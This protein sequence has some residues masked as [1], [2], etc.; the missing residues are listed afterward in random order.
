MAERNLDVTYTI[1]WSLALSNVI[2]TGLCIVLAP[3]ISQLTAIRYPLIAPFMMLAISFAAFQATRSLN[4]L[5]A[6]LG[7]GL[8]GVLLRRFGWS[9]PAFLIGF[10]LANGAERHLYQ[11]VQFAGWSFITRPIV[12]VILAVTLLSLWAGLR[13]RPGGT[14]TVHTEGSA[15]AARAGARP[16][17]PVRPGGAGRIRLHPAA[18]AEELVP[19]ADHAGVGRDR[20]RAGDAPAA[21][22][23]GARPRGRG[24]RQFRQRGEQP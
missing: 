19:C 2:G 12:L 17:D 3:G 9:R 5:L 22:G 15:E 7:I 21:V 1:V 4:D 20:R 16:A 14:T 11:A 6:L 23:V 24:D 8:I 18:G 10:V 13:A